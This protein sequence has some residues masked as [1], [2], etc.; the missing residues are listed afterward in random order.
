MCSEI[1][2]SSIEFLFV[3]NVL[4]CSFAEVLTFSLEFQYF[5]NMDES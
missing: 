1:L 3:L 2:F 5:C 4:K